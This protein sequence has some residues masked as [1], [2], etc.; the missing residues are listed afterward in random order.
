MEPEAGR[1][2]PPGEP[3]AARRCRRRAARGR[4]GAGA[5]GTLGARDRAVERYSWD[6][7]A[8][9]ARRDL[10]V[11]HRARA[12]RSPHEVPRRRP[13][14]GSGS[15]SRASRRRSCC[16]SGAGPS[17]VSSPTRSGSSNWEW[18]VA[19]DRAEPPVG[20]RPR[21]APGTSVIEQAMPPPRPRF[22]EVFSAFGV[23]L[24]ANAVLPGRIGELA[25]VAVLT[26]HQQQRRRADA[27]ATLVGTVFAHRVFDLFPMLLLIGYVISDREDPALGADEPHDLRRGRLRALRVRAGECA[28][29]PPLGA[30]RSRAGAEARDDGAPRPRRHARA[31]ARGDRRPPAVP[32]A[33]RSSCSRSGRRC[34]RSTSTS[35]CPRRGS[36]SS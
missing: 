24:F 36:S 28:A 1:L 25:R 35:R 18:V 17:G 3:S 20:G 19:R 10:R 13:G 23:G 27:W 29:A 16:S 5:A 12:A 14:G 6:G 15:C 33:G 21:R 34:A 30:R 8:A 22:R 9:A 26:R 32:S 31:G 7:I 2:V 4:A 11:A